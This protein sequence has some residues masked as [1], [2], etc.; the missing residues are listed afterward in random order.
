M[1]RFVKMLKGSKI[2]PLCGAGIGNLEDVLEAKRLGCKG[3]L[4]SSAI[5]KDKKPER[6]LK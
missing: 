2:I 6:F 5:A 3:I 1:E 4:I